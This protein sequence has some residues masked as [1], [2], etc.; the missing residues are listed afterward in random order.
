MFSYVHVY[1]GPNGVHFVG[2]FQPFRDAIKFICSSLYFRREPVCIMLYKRLAV[3]MYVCMYV[4][5][6]GHLVS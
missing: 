3:W 2:T 6:P 1:K 5:G 4:Y